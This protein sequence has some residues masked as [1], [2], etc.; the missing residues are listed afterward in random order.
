MK[1]QHLVRPGCEN[2][3]NFIRNSWIKSHAT[4]D[5][6]RYMTKQVYFDNHTSLVN[7]LV[8]YCKA[9]I[10]C[11]EEDANHIFA[12]VVYESF[13]DVLIIHYTYTKE[14]YRGLGIAS[15]IIET[16]KNSVPHKVVMA[17]HANEMFPF[18]ERKHK[19]LY[20][21]YLLWRKRDE[22]DRH[23]QAS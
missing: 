6:R 21:P 7:S 8:P 11:D 17:T 19:L 10:A 9:A 14:V 20:N 16:I 4:S 23:N 1:A 18:L 22:K 2:D 12:Y 5:F 15:K 3:L 13:N